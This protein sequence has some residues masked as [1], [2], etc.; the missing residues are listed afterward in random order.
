MSTQHIFHPLH[1]PSPPPSSR[2]ELATFA[3]AELF[4]MSSHCSAALVCNSSSTSLSSSPRPLD[5]TI[6]PPPPLPASFSHPAINHLPPSSPT[7]TPSNSSSPKNNT[8]PPPPSRPLQLPK[9]TSS[10]RRFRNAKNLSLN[11]PALSQLSSLSLNTPTGTLQTAPI[12]ASSIMDIAPPQTSIP[13]TSSCSF[14]K[15]DISVSSSKMI[16][17]ANSSPTH[18][19]PSTRKKFQH[20][21]MGSPFEP[22]HSPTYAKSKSMDATPLPSIYSSIPQLSSQSPPHLPPQHQQTNSPRDQQQKPTLSRTLSIKIPDSP[23]KALAPNLLSSTQSHPSTLANDFSFPEST[24]PDSTQTSATGSSSYSSFS[25]SNSSSTSSDRVVLVNSFMPVEEC[26][27]TT[28]N[29]YPNGPLAVIGS[30]IYLYSEPTRAEAAKFDVIINVA[31]E[32]KNPFDDS[33]DTAPSISSSTKNTENNIKPSISL[34]SCGYSTFSESL[35]SDFSTSLPS[36]PPSSLES[37]SDIVMSSPLLS[38]DEAMSPIVPAEPWAPL[39]SLPKSTH[40]HQQQQK[41]PEYIYVSWDHNSKLT[42]DLEFLTTLMADRT[43][44]G[45]RILVHCQCGVSRSASLIVAYVMSQN[46][47]GLHHAYSWVKDKSPA[48]SPNMT[49]IYQ[50]MEWGKMLNI[51]ANDQDQQD[52]PQDEHAQP[53]PQQS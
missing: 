31:R 50:L 22:S 17:P 12:R 28:V 7:P 38:I 49:L 11:V 18:R 24:G 43:A 29:A 52:Q 6:S 45:K 27:E 2:S 51:P 9:R 4:I 21:S 36:S 13:Q 40:Q 44:E 14:R 39:S 26:M 42:A 5:A 32:V 19:S 16:S 35:N 23:Q 3:P 25:H 15:L 10:P 47:W 8:L 33:D 34:K 20:S 53:S 30:N 37:H 46:R 1:P 41:Q 48:I